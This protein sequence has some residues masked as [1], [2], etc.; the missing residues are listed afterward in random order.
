MFGSSLD[1]VCY[2]VLS[3]AWMN[4]QHVLLL[5]HYILLSCSS[6]LSGIYLFI[7]LS[8]YSVTILVSISFLLVSLYA[9]RP[10][11]RPRR[12]CVY[13]IRMDLQEVGCRYVDWTGLAQDRD[14][15]QTLVSAV[16]N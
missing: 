11:G 3:A 15:W 6:Y 14:R 13:N 10:L 9:S 16:M 7:S 12:R 2:V 5:L 4:L 1:F 8:S